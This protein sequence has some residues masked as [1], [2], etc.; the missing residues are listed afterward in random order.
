ME[1]KKSPKANLE[2]YSKLFML[3]GLLFALFVVYKGIEYKSTYVVVNLGDGSDQEE[4][5]EEIPITQQE[6]EEV[7]PP[8]PPPPPAPEIIEVVEDDKEIEE[9]I[10]ESTETDEDEVIEV[11]E[12]VE[13]VVEE[14]VIDEV[15]PFSVIESV[16]VFPGCKGN[17]AA[18]TKCLNSKIRKHINNKFNVDLAQDL[19]L[20]AGKK[21]INVQFLIDKQGN[22]TDIKS[23]APHPRLQKEAERIIKLLP[24]MT[25]GKQR[26][27]PVKVRY[28]LP[29]VFN[30]ED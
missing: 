2:N 29:I 14:E 1:I 9:T 27:K 26:N 20:S 22:I 6:I 10:L 7:K 12:E 19:G 13:E 24:K 21:K 23:R 11:P 16:P 4:L 3:L 28:N 17:K 15:V 25:P 5:E 30:V 18:L 8:P